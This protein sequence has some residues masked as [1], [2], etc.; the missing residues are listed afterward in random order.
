MTLGGSYTL[1]GGGGG[2][3]TVTTVGTGNLAPLFT[4][5]V[6]NPT[7]TPTTNYTLANA[8]AGTVL[9]NPTGSSAAPS[10]TASPVLTSIT[11]GT[12][13]ASGLTSGQCVQTGS[14][15]VLTTTGAACGSGG[16]GGSNP[17]SLVLTDTVTST[18]Y[19]LSVIGGQLKLSALGSTGTATP[20]NGI[21]NG[22]SYYE[23]AVTSG[24]LNVITKT[25][26][27][28]SQSVYPLV[29]TNFGV[30]YNLTVTTGGALQIA[31]N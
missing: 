25:S 5:S 27:Y 17:T 22:S 10:Y 1:S 31:V 13:T 15:G 16:G 19:G 14:G 2:G 11:A 3:G 9:G 12:V 24:S 8:A 26:S 30:L 29:D 20:V 4:A 7:T 21:Y 28:P 6:S 23:I 18:R